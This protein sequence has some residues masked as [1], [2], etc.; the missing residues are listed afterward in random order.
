MRRGTILAILLAIATG[1]Y[2]QPTVT[3][4]PTRAGT[5]TGAMIL[6]I[7][8]CIKGATSCQIG[9]CRF[10]KQDLVNACAGSCVNPPLTAGCY[11]VN[12]QAYCIDADGAN[13]TGDGL[14]PRVNSFTPPTPAPTATQPTLAPAG[15]PTSAPTLA[16]A[17]PAGTPTLVP[18][19]APTAPPGT[20]TSVPTLAPGPTS[21]PS[22]SV[23]TWA[24]SINRN[25]TATSPPPGP[26]GLV[27]G[28]AIG[29]G[30]LFLLLVLVSVCVYRG[31]R[32]RGQRETELPEVRD[33]HPEAPLRPFD[34][35]HYCA[36]SAGARRAPGDCTVGQH[37]RRREAEGQVGVEGELAP[38]AEAEGVCA[39]SA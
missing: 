38:L 30:V 16:P 22:S 26:N 20:P 35:M 21:A 3:F 17:A 1:A 33:T 6:A 14:C 8:Q 11:T 10:C 7:D 23:P 19:L 12:P 18:S 28:L 32:K 29:G 15:T 37:V 34:V 4:T 27:L 39:P 25:G 13:Y 5:C 24:P 31:R 36:R 2:A 9:V